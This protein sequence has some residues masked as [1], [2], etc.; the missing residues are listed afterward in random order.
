MSAPNP[1]LLLPIETPVKD[2]TEKQ[3]VKIQAFSNEAQKS[4]VTAKRQGITATEF[5]QL[6]SKLGNIEPNTQEGAAV[7]CILSWVILSHT[8][9][10]QLIAHINWAHIPGKT[11]EWLLNLESDDQQDNV[12][13]EWHDSGRAISTFHYESIAE[14]GHQEM[15]DIL[16]L[17]A[18]GGVRTVVFVEDHYLIPNQFGYPTY[19]TNGRYKASTGAEIFQEKIKI[20]EKKIQAK[21]FEIKRMHYWHA[22]CLTKGEPPIIEKTL[23]GVK[24]QCAKRREHTFSEPAIRTMAFLDGFDLA[25]QIHRR[26]IEEGH[27][28]P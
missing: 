14:A 9:S 5:N 23:Q 15:A 18:K 22:K 19:D 17:A 27:F 28:T 12:S 25:Q 26:Y 2:L 6:R 20:A 24:I 7:E 16:E 21:E 13:S 11:W 3:L 8:D 4:I 10:L 1:N